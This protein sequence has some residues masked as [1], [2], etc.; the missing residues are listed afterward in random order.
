MITLLRCKSSGE[1]LEFDVE[2]KTDQH[3]V[4]VQDKDK[5]IKETKILSMNEWEEKR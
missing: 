5:A 1:I 4:L 3:Y 2:F